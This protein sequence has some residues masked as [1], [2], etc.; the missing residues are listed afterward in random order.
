MHVVWLCPLQPLSLAGI[1]ILVQ[2]V[3]YQSQRTLFSQLRENRTKIAA[4]GSGCSLATEPTAEISHFWNIPQVI[5]INCMTCCH[6]EVITKNEVSDRWQPNICHFNI[7]IDK[8][9]KG[10]IFTWP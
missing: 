10:K 9:F 7:S 3:R 5:A 8:T 1:T 4:I 6:N 2:C